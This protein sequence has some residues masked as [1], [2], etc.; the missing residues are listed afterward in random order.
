MCLSF[1]CERSEV[2]E[3]SSGEKECF[4]FSRKKKEKTN[5][6]EEVQL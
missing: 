3:E 6:Q 2:M 1:G 5:K 4:L